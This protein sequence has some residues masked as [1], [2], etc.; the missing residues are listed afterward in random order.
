MKNLRKIS[1]PLA[2]FL[3]VNFLS[4]LV[5]PNIAWALTAGPTAPEYSSFEPVDMTDMVN[6]NTGDFVYNVPL[7]EV[8]GPAG[9]YP[10]SLS[11]HA[12]IQP[13][14]EASWVGLGWVLN[15]GA[16]NR[17]VNGYPDDYRKV[18]NTV[19]D[20][21]RGGH[22]VITKKEVAIA[23]SDF[24]NFGV[25]LGS[26]ETLD[27]Y[28]GYSV[29]QSFNLGMSKSFFGVDFQAGYSN[30]TSGGANFGVTAS[31]GMQ[32]ISYSTSGGFDVST[33]ASIG[34]KVGQHSVAKASYGTN[35]LTFGY[36][37]PNL[38]VSGSDD[39]F[40]LGTSM[41]SIKANS[42]GITVG[43]FGAS[44]S[45]NHQAGRISTSSNSTSLPPIPIAPGMTLNLS[46]TW[47]RYW[48]DETQDTDVYGS[49]YNLTD[50]VDYDDASFDTFDDSDP[51]AKL[52]DENYEPHRKLGGGTYPDVDLYQVTGQGIGGIIKPFF[53]REYLNRQNIKRRNDNGDLYT[54]TRNAP[55][56]KHLRFAQKTQFRFD[57][58][59]ANRLEYNAPS[60]HQSYTPSGEGEMEINLSGQYIESGTS[61]D[62]GYAPTG[63]LLGKLHSGQVIEWKT[64]QDF[65]NDVGPFILE[66]DAAGFQREEKPT[67]QI[68]AFAITN[69]SGITYHYSLPV[70]SYDEHTFSEKIRDE[71][72]LGF[73][74]PETFNHQQK[75]EPYAYTWLLTAVTG[76]DYVDRNH[77][78][79]ADE[80]DWGHWTAFNYGEWTDEYQWRNPS[81]GFHRDP[82]NKFRN[83]SMGKK[84]IYYLDAIKTETHTAFFVKSLREDGK[85]ATSNDIPFILDRWD[86]VY[87]SS[88]EGHFLPRWKEQ[89]PGVEER[90]MNTYMGFPKSLLKLDYIALWDNEQFKKVRPLDLDAFKTK[91]YLKNRSQTYAWSYDGG[92]SNAG[93]LVDVEKTVK[94]LDYSNVLD[95]YDDQ[96]L[97]LRS[98][99]LK[100]VDFK[101]DY[102]LMPKTPNS[103]P[104]TFS[105]LRVPSFDSVDYSLGGKLTLT[106]VQV[107]GHGGIRSMPPT[108]FEYNDQNPDYSRYKTDNWGMYKSDHSGKEED[109]SNLDKITTLESG[110]QADAWSLT[111]I[112]NPL[113]AVT[114]V[115]YESDTYR[116]AIMHK[117]NSLI[118]EGIEH[119]QELPG[120]ESFNGLKLKINS[121]GVD[122]RD[123]LKK[124]DEIEVSMVIGSLIELPP[125]ISSL[126]NYDTAYTSLGKFGDTRIWVTRDSGWDS[127]PVI[128]HVWSDAVAVDHIYS[129]SQ[130]VNGPYA[131]ILNTIIVTGNISIINR[132]KVTGGGLR[133]KS[134]GIFDPLSNVTNT[135]HYDYKI[136]FSDKS[137]GVTSYEP[138]MLD[139]FD[140]NIPDR[141]KSKMK[142]ML[143]KEMANF[144]KHVRHLPG[145][146]VRYEY[147]T[148]RE[149]VTKGTEV[150]FREGYSVYHFQAF[151]PRMVDFDQDTEQELTSGNTT[152]K[153]KH[154]RVNDLTAQ[155]G[156]L[157]SVTLYNNQDEKLSETI[158]HHLLDQLLSGEGEEIDEAYKHQLDSYLKQGLVTETFANAR[159]VKDYR[160]HVSSPSGQNAV[161]GVLTQKTKYPVITTGQ[162]NINYVKGGTSKTKNLAFDFYSGQITEAYSEDIY[163]N[164][165]WTK[166]IPAYQLKGPSNVKA[167]RHMGLKSENPDFKN[168][169]TQNG[170]SITYKLNDGFDP[171]VDD[172]EHDKAS[173][174]GASV[175]LWESGRNNVHTPAGIVTQNSQTMGQHI[176]RKHGTLSFI[177]NG[178]L[179]EDG[180]HSLIN[181]EDN[182]GLHAS[183]R[184]LQDM[185]GWRKNGHATK[186]DM[187]SHV[188]EVVDINGHY[189]ATKFD[190]RYEYALSSATNAKYNEF[191]FS[192]AE[193]EP[194]GGSLYFGGDVR[195]NTGTPNAN[196]SPHTGKKV[197]FVNSGKGFSFRSEDLMP[198][199]TYRVSVWTSRPAHTKV[200]YRTGNGPVKFAETQSNQVDDWYQL[201][202]LITMPE[203]VT[204]AE[205]FV[206][207]EASLSLDDFMFAPVDAGITAYVYNEWGQLSDL[208]NSNNLS[209][210]YE[211][212]EAGRLTS[213]WVESFQYGKRKISDQ[214]IHYANY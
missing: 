86:R 106:S 37:A 166:S 124:G 128:H 70:Y 12:G 177:G 206:Q 63:L 136:P 113:G 146:G 140:E 105:H 142:R 57:G 174:M 111:K 187:N 58:E 155:I 197:L 188:L 193:D 203:N 213:I 1:R 97:N 5:F 13:D 103:F 160:A 25:T 170:A 68:G 4:S 80:G 148:L 194:F 85:S 87:P 81:T 47:L 104:D 157:K 131:H 73:L 205:V 167:Y 41:A 11:Y 90:K 33:G 40:S 152:L 159:W 202:S 10:L 143:Y 129:G 59:F 22:Q 192:G 212:D 43:A 51:F 3:L 150:N 183:G 186:Y 110:E 44:F 67:D 15:A 169:L 196:A 20:F 165:Y 118:L 161:L 16:I 173:L 204:S 122:L 200:G 130:Q 134:L 191:A 69:L 77:N 162:T 151:D 31:K 14:Q 35:G 72:V 24:F 65:R 182:L 201:S 30:S 195:L 27:S 112:I 7:L 53:Y 109:R 184:E 185:T 79:L 171:E 198:G 164:K 163:G 92:L 91:S 176:Y 123:L 29:N 108:K 180:S 66:N 102:S 135:T 121:N 179:N 149:S 133:V 82:D 181:L 18:K 55:L 52:V 93:Y 21:W 154:Y 75:L 156:A 153:S 42:T 19:R 26:T 38:K 23:G 88:L 175:Q 137:S 98:K 78:N 8:P 127:S 96:Q 48:S 139:T 54:D 138:T 190:S 209:T 71:N 211:Y 95:N 107:L 99:A 17:A 115:A 34:I 89:K 46:R 125:V 6:L 116:D 50:V 120:Q 208:I 74:E 45:Q 132:R 84:E 60:F 61:G 119:I 56:Y 126:R 83:F 2:A 158:N 94:I 64:N 210:H 28:Q 36:E 9:G 147:V 76:P 207:A 141:A 144:V 100:V 114:E 49:L 178:T 39:G 32:S 168:M 189:A 199:R 214:T 145:P 101:S 117:N 172:P 62:D